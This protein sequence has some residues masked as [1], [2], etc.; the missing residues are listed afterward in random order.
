MNLLSKKDLLGTLFSRFLSLIVFTLFMLSS[1]STI[2]A[3]GPASTTF[4]FFPKM[5]HYQG[6]ITALGNNLDSIDTGITQLEI[7]FSTPA[8]SLKV[9]NIPTSITEG[10]YKF[11]TIFGDPIPARYHI[12]IGPG[13]PERAEFDIYIGGQKA[14]QTVMFDPE[15]V[16]GCKINNCYNVTLD[17]TLD[18]IP[19]P[20]PTAVPPTPTPLA[21]VNPSLYS[22]EIRIGSTLVP[23]N[24]E[25]YAILVDYQSEIVKTSGGRYSITLNPGTIN[26]VG[27]DFNLIIQGVYS[28]TTL[29]FEANVFTSDSNFLF[30]D[31]EVTTLPI[32]MLLEAPT[33]TPIP[34]PMPTPTPPEPEKIIIVVTPTP[35]N[36]KPQS[37]VAESTG[38]RESEPL[39]E[40]LA[41][42][43][44]GCSSSGGGNSSISIFSLLLALLL[45][46]L[47]YRKRLK[48]TK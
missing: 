32:P 21:L 39:A 35:S 44:G 7:V 36:E 6:S 17:L 18:V 8:Q 25:V 10:Q 27:Q 31:F 4:E 43:G 26:Y 40:P 38:P 24:V 22:G 34:T 46:V 23:D 48:F 45:T 41:E 11:S 16:N 5:V 14:N 42:Q 3:E 1:L 12:D 20:T 19:R 28:L 13:V 9:N 29:P 37:L 33:P 30:P 15:P 47:S 2:K